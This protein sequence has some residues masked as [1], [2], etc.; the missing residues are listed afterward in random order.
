MKFEIPK[1]RT[2]YLLAGAGAL[3]AVALLGGAAFVAG[4]FVAGAAF[5]FASA[6]G[7]VFAFA[8]V[9]TA[10]FAFAFASVVAVGSS[11]FDDRT[12]TFPVSAGIE[13]IRAVIMN[14]VAATI[15]TFDKTVAVPRGAKAELE[16]L[17]VN[18]AP[19]SVLPGCN[20]TAAT[21]IRH[22]RKNRPYRM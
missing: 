2:N 13:S 3:A 12:D 16:T 7:A 19:A 5:E 15:V 1:L 6:A 11:G 17:L 21:K 9:G 10:T 18:K 22:E 14:D 8:S 4:A 20:K